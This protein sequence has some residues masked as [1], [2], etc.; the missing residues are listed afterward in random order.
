MSQLLMGVIAKTWH[1]FLTFPIW[2]LLFVFGIKINEIIS[3]ARVP[4]SILC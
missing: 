2:Q 1:T 4:F 3:F